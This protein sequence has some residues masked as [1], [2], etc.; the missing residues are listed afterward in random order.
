M[1][2]KERTR[3]L[4]K[5]E[6]IEKLQK[7]HVL[8]VGLG[9]VGSFAAEMLCRAG[10]GKL[11]LVDH[12]IYNLTNLNR[13]IGAFHS[14]I[15]LSKVEVIK[16]RLLDINPDIEI[17]ALKEYMKDEKMVGL[18]TAEKYTYVVDAIDTFSPKVFFIYHCLNNGLQLVSSMGTGGKTKPDDIRIADFSETY[19]C[20]LAYVLRKKLRKKNVT[21][22]FKAVFSIEKLNKNAVI[23]I[24]EE[25]KKSNVGTISYMPPIFGG[26]CA[27]VVINSIL[28]E[29]CDG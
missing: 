7:A 24:E 9:G 14:T 6:G 4:V 13:Q 12:D 10:I 29:E 16:A 27:S 28:K 20:R 1:D 19:E 8:V 18:L 22:G 3:L 15:G 26:F 23:R 25:N 11:T 21:G 17:I 2:W 5:E